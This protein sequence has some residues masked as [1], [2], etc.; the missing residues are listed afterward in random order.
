ML[1]YY[2]LPLLCFANTCIIVFEI[3][4]K[5]LSNPL[6]VFVAKLKWDKPKLEREFQE[7]KKY[8]F[9]KFFLKI[10]TKTTDTWWDAKLDLD[11]NQ[12][13]RPL[14]VKNQTRLTCKVKFDGNSIDLIKAVFTSKSKKYCHGTLF[15]LEE[16]A[17]VQALENTHHF[18]DVHC[19][20]A[21]QVNG[22]HCYQASMLSSES[23]H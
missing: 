11:K 4:L 16:K 1:Y 13:R 2:S 7:S 10:H 6:L 22:T 14:K 23:F 8:S 18:L 5:I 19:L 21:R 20:R 15:F 9:L 3:E 17:N 12:I